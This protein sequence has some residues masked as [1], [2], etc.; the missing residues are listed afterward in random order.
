M[1]ATVL[2]GRYLHRNLD[3][4]IEDAGIPTSSGEAYVIGNPG[5]GLAASV[6]KQLGYNKA[7]IPQRKYNA[8]QAELDTRFIR[9]LS[10]NLNYTWSR[11]FGNYS[12]LANPD[13]LNAS[14]GGR[15]NPNVSREFD[16]PWVGFTASGVPDNGIL[17]LDRTHVFKA[18]GTYSY[19]WMR[20][21]SQTTDF[22]FFTTA[23]SG[24]PLT[25]FVSIFGIPIVE[26]KRGDRGRSPIF[27]QTDLNLTHRIR[28]GGENR[29]TIAFDFNVINV[30]NHNTP[31]AFAQNKTSA[32][33]ALA[34]TDV[35]PSGDT[36]AVTNL[37]TS[38]GV[39]AQYAAKEATICT[40]ATSGICGT[41]VARS[42][43]FGKPIAWQDPR[44]V[45][46]GVRFIF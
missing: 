27:K 7:A 32:Y 12:G 22:S 23:E 26:T 11:L 17:P 42:A 38:S 14:G 41:G 39:L 1:R 18:S 13:E 37:L 31:L 25:T 43:S 45:R 20:S 10:L 24:T 29:F 2:T 28:F 19:D 3:Q 6:Y 4:A 34:K 30:F 16:E 46:F 5:Q 44:L 15:T 9:N 8:I 21:K 33:W 40:T 35:L 36:V